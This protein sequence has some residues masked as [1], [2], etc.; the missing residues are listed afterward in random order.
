MFGVDQAGFTVS[1]SDTELEGDTGQ[2]PPPKHY[3]GIYCN[4][5]VGV[6]KGYTL[7]L[8]RYREGS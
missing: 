6:G 3:D 8:M 2:V 7:S 4:Q 5:S 1:Q